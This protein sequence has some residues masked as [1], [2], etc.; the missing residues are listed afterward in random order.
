[1]NMGRL[2]GS[3]FVKVSRHAARVKTVNQQFV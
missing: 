3:V 2:L 1:M